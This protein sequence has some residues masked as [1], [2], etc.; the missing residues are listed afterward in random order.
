MGQILPQIL[1]DYETPQ[2]IS[3]QTQ[4][5]KTHRSKCRNKEVGLIMAINTSATNHIECSELNAEF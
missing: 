5:H 2:S 1:A 3:A 4:A